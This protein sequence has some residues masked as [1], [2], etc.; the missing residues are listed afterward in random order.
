[1]NMCVAFLEMC[2]VCIVSSLIN[3][4]HLVQIP[5]ESV[6]CNNQLL[7]ECVTGGPAGVWIVEDKH[8]VFN[9]EKQINTKLEGGGFISP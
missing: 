4:V 9:S 7:Y 6:C 3:T 1:M 2:S 8:Y 5:D